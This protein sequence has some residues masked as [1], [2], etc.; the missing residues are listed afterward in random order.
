MQKDTNQQMKTALGGTD[1]EY[2]ADPPTEQC[3]Y[4]T[5]QIVCLTVRFLT[6]IYLF[7]IWGA[8]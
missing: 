5:D 3:R 6:A 8:H 2:D 7:Q 4:A 1:E